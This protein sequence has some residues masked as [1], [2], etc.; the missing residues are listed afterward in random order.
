MRDTPAEDFDL[1]S[2]G[3]IHDLQ[4]PLSAAAGAFRVLETLLGQGDQDT[5]FFRDT[6][7]TGLRNASAIIREWHALLAQAHAPEVSQ[8]VGLRLVVNELCADLGLRDVVT[9]ETLP[10]AHVQREKIRLVLRNLLDNARRY[11]RPDVPMQIT[12]GSTWRPEHHCIFV[13]DNGC[14]IARKHHPILFE[15]F[16]RIPRPGTTDHPPGLGVGLHLVKRI[17]AQHGGRVWVSS[18]VRR[19]ATF[20]F[21]LP[22]RR[23]E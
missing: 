18:R 10:R 16:R 12:V 22:K 2:L 3:L 8:N 7:R 4:S 14:G 15:P 13:R 20:F 19:G 21:T 11:G 6:V 17:V 23:P 9:V 5:R 1:T